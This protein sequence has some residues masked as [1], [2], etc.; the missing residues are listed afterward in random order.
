MADL[1]FTS[2]NEAVDSLGCHQSQI[3]ELTHRMVCDGEGNTT[4]W[5]IGQLIAQALKKD[6][7]ELQKAVKEL[8]QKAEAQG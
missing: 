3:D 5:A 4:M 7:D 6:I 8:W 2:I 1:S